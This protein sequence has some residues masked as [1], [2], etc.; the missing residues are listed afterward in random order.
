[1]PSLADNAAWAETWALITGLW[2][3]W[4]PTDPQRDLFKETLQSLLQSR[5]RHAV[6]AAASASRYK[7]PTLAEIIEA[8]DGASSG[9]VRHRKAELDKP[10]RTPEEAA[11]ELDAMRND[12]MRVDRDRLRAGLE[13]AKSLGI[14][15]I[16]RGIDPDDLA[17]WPPMAIGL[18]WAAIF[19]PD[20]RVAFPESFA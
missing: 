6:K 3:S 11:A 20:P 8:H 5:V 19:A 4:K 18:T 9:R 10:P 13:A 1:M 2:P 7:A 12:L 17:T 15:V 16:D 14:V